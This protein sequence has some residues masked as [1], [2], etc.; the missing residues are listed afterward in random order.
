MNYVLLGNILKNARNALH[1]TQAEVAK[2][3]NTTYQTISNW[4]RGVSKMD[5]ESLDM[6]CSLYNLSTSNTIERVIGSTA[7]PVD[8]AKQRLNDNYDL[9]NQD[10]KT[11]LVDYSDDLVQSGKYE[12]KNSEQDYHLSTLVK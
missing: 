1:I 6:L 7:T 10:G 4:E 2:R 5:I 12:E 9:L 8:L 3:L 11:K